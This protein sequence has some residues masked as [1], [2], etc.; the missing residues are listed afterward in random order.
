MAKTSG[1]G[2]AAVAPEIDAQG[3]TAEEF[4]KAEFEWELCHECERDEEDHTAVIGPFSSWFAYCNNP[5]D[6]Q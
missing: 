3:L 6:E 1:N 5:R 2:F 4:M